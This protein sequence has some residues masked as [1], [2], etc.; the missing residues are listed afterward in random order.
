MT[1]DATSTPSPD[2]L[3]HCA[4]HPEVETGLSCGR[5]GTPICPR[6]MMHTPGG[7]R[8]PD[9]GRGPTL[10]IYQVG[11]MDI[12][13]ATLVSAPLGAL[14]GVLGAM[15]LPTSSRLGLLLVLVGVFAGSAAGTLVA[16]AIMRVTRKRGPMIQ[17][18]AIAALLTMAV[19]R[20]VLIGGID[21]NVL[22][23]DIA[24]GLALVVAISAAFGRLR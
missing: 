2:A 14:L 1:T 17:G 19:V 20:L 15:L 21:A 13:R 16:E 9:C 12:V 5:C 10:P 11:T 4:R 22:A 24:G 3:P 23:R 18:I 6:C 7:A 8:C